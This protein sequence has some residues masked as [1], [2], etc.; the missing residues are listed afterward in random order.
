MMIDYVSCECCENHTEI[1]Y[2]GEFLDA[3]NQ[4]INIL[5]QDSGGDVDSLYFCSPECLVKYFYDD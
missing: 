3:N 1:D 2:D 5:V 4:W